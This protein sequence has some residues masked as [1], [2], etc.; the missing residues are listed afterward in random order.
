MLKVDAPARRSKLILP[1]EYVC[2]PTDSTGVI[3][4]APHPA[5]GDMSRLAR[6]HVRKLHTTGGHSPQTEY[7]RSRVSRDGSEGP[8][9]RG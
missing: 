3:L 4:C 1:A 2:L 8:S 9:G 6:T 5:F 7:R